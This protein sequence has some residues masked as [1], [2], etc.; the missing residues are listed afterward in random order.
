MKQKQIITVLFILLATAPLLSQKKGV[1]EQKTDPFQTQY[2]SFKSAPELNAHLFLYNKA[3]ACKFKKVHT[4]SLAYYSFKDK[5]K[6]I[7][8]KDLVQLNAVLAFY[9]DSLLGKD[10]LFDSLMRDFSDKLGS[11]VSVTERWQSRALEKMSVFQPVFM[12]VYWPAIDEANKAWLKTIRPE[13]VRLETIIVPEL[14]R[15]YQTKLPEEKIRVDLT[16]YATWAGAYSYDDT[17]CHVI[18]STTH[19]SNQGDL[20]PE[21]IFHET[22]HFLVN[23]LEQ[24]IK[25]AAKGK[26]IKQSINLWH[27]MIFYTTGYVLQKHYAGEG[28]TFVPY[29]VQ[30]KFEDKFPDFK[31]SVEACKQYWDDYCQSK[32]PFD[33]AVKNIVTSVTEKK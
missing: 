20:A 7:Q 8:E 4:D 32:T 11:T 23:T 5:L 17:F 28:K 13:L 30:M 24:Q 9:K 6:L 27:N 15:I 14:E 1:K 22:S 3:M 33:Q 10:L 25:E 16:S 18:F 26:D 29:Y 31:A 2:F 12:K 21:V 19:H